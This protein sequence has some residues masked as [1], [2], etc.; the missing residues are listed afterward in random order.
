[1]NVRYSPLLVAL[2][3]ALV[4]TIAPVRAQE[5][6]PV[7]PEPAPL[8]VM[9]L[10]AHPD[11]EDGLTM[12][13]YRRVRNAVVHSV[14]YTRGEGGQNEIG[15]ELYAALGAIRTAET[16]AA[17]RHLGTQ[18]R[19][20]N[21][22]DFG[23]SKRAAETFER[24]GGEG[25]VTE[26]LV[27]LIRKLKPDVL[28]TNHDTLTVGPR[29]Q[30][31]HHQ[32]VGISA[33]R[34]MTLAAD[35]SF[36]PE[37]LAEE[38]VDLWQPQRLFLR[39]WRGGQD[40]AHVRVPS[41][42]LIPGT[43]RPAA[44]VAATAVAEHRS[45]GFDA[46]AERFRQGTTYFVLLASAPDAPPLPEGATDLAAG[47][48]PNPYAARIDLTHR[49]DA[50]RVEPFPEAWLVLGDSVAV[51]GGRL[52]LTSRPAPGHTLRLTGAIDTLL[53]SGGHHILSVPAAARPTLP[54]ETAQYD[55]FVSSPPVQAAFYDAAGQRV[56]AEHLA[57]EIAPPLVLNLAEGVALPGGLR[58]RVLLRYGANRLTAAGRAFDPG[59]DSVLVTLVATREGLAT[60]LAETARRVRVHEGRFEAALAFE[61]PETLRAGRY[62]V[63]VRA[64]APPTVATTVG[65]RAVLPLEGHVLP[66][67]AVA[68]GLRV[69]LV[70]SY[71]DATEAALRELGVDVVPLDSTML[72]TSD[73]SGLHTILVDIR[74]YLVRPDLRAH[75]DRLLDWV[76]D[77]GHLVVTYQKTFEWNDAHPDPFIENASN[78]AGFAPY[79]L[80][81]GRGRVTDAEAEVTVLVPDHPLFNTPNSISPD[82]W[83]GWVQERGLY[84][85]AA[86]DDRYVELLAM[87][88]PGEAPQRGS[89]L[90]A[91]YGE[92][93]YLYSALG[94]YRQLGAFNPGA[95]RVL[96]NIVSL[97]LVDD[98]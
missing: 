59:I 32:A 29:V 93:T 26:R 15:P 34:A 73:F 6:L 92:G 77:G 19:F 42:H 13:Y 16:E 75:N 2:V 48:P 84:F 97:P 68:E 95:Y 65:P 86:Y 89:T 8:V 39:L 7:L 23:Y 22:D 9:N 51:P 94:W 33:Y 14:I 47:L 20:L 85:P 18:V 87:A 52:S 24:W 88:D 83:T 62:D 90:L 41:G 74:A 98:R 70:R 45:Q 25:A 56:N 60:P 76:R 64:E 3:V 50:G 96:A 58:E 36:H 54:K 17:A 53:V 81:L 91:R 78:P 37:H 31:G 40:T 66:E 4:A 57:V 44:D 79:P 21:F 28:F 55:R 27:Y 61:L 5:A 80:A 12:A 82:D 72:A 46:F 69:G 38:G 63:T 10:A 71:D 30:H 11:D 35:P 67:V 49:I 43:A 1:M